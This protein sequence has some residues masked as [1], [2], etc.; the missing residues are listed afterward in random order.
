MKQLTVIKRLAD[1]DRR[2]GRHVYTGEDLASLCH[3]DNLRALQATVARLVRSGVLER[4]ARNVFVYALS[5]NR[6]S[7]Y[8][9]EHIAVAL[10]R[11]ERSYVSLE[12]ALSEYG[13]ILQVPIDRTTVMTTGRKG[14]YKT[15]YGVIEFT[16]TERS[17]SDIR[18]SVKDVGRP[19]KLATCRAAIRDLRRVGRNTHLIDEEEIEDEE[20]C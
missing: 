17:G 16:H 7:G 3:E 20:I 9:I 14:V 5:P 1:I 10:R 19:L 15:P 6:G 11:G 2:S 4:A 12:S 18:A 8:T 13:V